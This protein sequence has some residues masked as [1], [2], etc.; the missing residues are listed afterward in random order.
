MW[1]LLVLV[2]SSVNF[3]L[4]QHLLLLKNRFPFMCLAQ[5]CSPSQAEEQLRMVTTHKV[6][7]YTI[8]CIFHCKNFQFQPASRCF[9]DHFDRLHLSRLLIKRGSSVPSPFDLRDCRCR[10]VGFAPVGPTAMEQQQQQRVTW[11][12]LREWIHFLCKRWFLCWHL[13]SAENIQLSISSLHPS[14]PG[15]Q[16]A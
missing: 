9:P 16:A 15:R 7:I 12:I 4:H 10:S 13:P 3:W 14:H 8:R 1:S 11:Y 6:E 5:K 2:D